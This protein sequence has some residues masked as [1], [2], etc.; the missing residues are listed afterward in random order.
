MTSSWFFLSTY[1][2]II[3]FPLEHCSF[4]IQVIRLSHKHYLDVLESALADGS[5]VLLENIGETVRMTKSHRT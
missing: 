4:L 2:T 5:T 1:L 3:A